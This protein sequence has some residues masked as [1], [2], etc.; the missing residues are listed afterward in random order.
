MTLK[1]CFFS[2]VVACLLFSA[3]PALVQDS[4]GNHPCG[5]PPSG[6]LTEVVA[7]SITSECEQTSLLET[8]ADALVTIYLIGASPTLAQDNPALAQDIPETAACGLPAAGLLSQAVTYTLTADCEQTGLLQIAA[9]AVITINGGGH[10]ITAPIDGSPA[11]AGLAGSTLNLNQLTVD[12]VD[13]S[14]SALVSTSGIFGATDVTFTRSKGGAALSAESGAQL[15][16]SHVLFARNVSSGADAEGSG[17]A[18]NVASGA[19]VTLEET[20]IRDNLFGGGAVV[21]ERGATSFTTRGC[22]TLVGNIPYNVVGEW[23]SEHGDSCSGTIGNNAPATIHAPELMAC[24][25]PGPGI[26]NQSES[27]TLSADCDRFGLWLLSDG[28]SISITGDG[29]RISSANPGISIITAANA[30]LSMENLTLDGVR[31]V[32][33]GSV[34]A[35]DFALRNARSQAFLNLGNASFTRALFANNVNVEP[36]FSASVLFGWTEY[37]NST[38]T[39]T[40]AIFR[41]NLGGDAALVNFRDSAFI[42]LNGCIT[43][44]GNA[45]ADNLWIVADAST[46]PCGLEFGPPWLVMSAEAQAVAGASDDLELSAFA[47][48]NR[49]IE[50]PGQSGPSPV[51]TPTPVPTSA[52]PTPVPDD[53]F[54]NLGAIGQ[55]C[56][57][58]EADVT[59]IHILGIAADSTGYF[60]LRV[61]QTDI[62]AAALGSLVA[63][64]DD[65]RVAVHR[66]ADGNITFSMGPNIEGKVHHVVLQ[67]D[68]NGAVISTIDRTGGVP[69]VVSNS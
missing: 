9:D 37:R 40:D 54:Q 10:S 63:S 18:L 51:P 55:L 7:Y 26:L 50:Y 53:C 57:I 12:G 44:E 43:F 59:T 36:R 16:L 60:L 42:A 3:S 24:G 21:V 62:D 32:N 20:V 15:N 45:P 39:F 56:R 22:L 1:R 58:G 34:A 4:G 68:L 6:Q 30:S 23:S 65:G 52:A 46:G 66:E 29:H 64:T 28:V 33:F 27:Y 19:A 67:G 2:I 14:R 5:Q 8:V 31:T 48:A 35:T 11:I 17:S 49:Q 69:G 13:L 41:N 25:I 61:T 47:A 38:A